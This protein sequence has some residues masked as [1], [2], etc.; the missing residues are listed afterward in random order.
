MSPLFDRRD[1]LEELNERDC[2]R[3]RESWGENDVAIN[4]FGATVTRLFNALVVPLK[5][6]GTEDKLLPC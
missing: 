1:V 3:E 5:I 2:S 4:A 6:C